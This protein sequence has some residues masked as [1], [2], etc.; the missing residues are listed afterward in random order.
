[1]YTHIYIYFLLSQTNGSIF[2]LIYLGDLFKLGY[3]E[4]SYSFFMFA[5]YSIKWLYQNFYLT[6]SI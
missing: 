6:Q 5:L 1:M 4:L 3:K 2:F